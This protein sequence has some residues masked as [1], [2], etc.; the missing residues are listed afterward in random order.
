M[1]QKI[2]TAPIINIKKINGNNINAEIKVNFA[3][4]FD[5]KLSTGINL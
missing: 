1:N 2:L 4:F 5:L 3:L